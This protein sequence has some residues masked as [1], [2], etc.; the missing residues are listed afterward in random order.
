MPSHQ[1]SSD[2]FFLGS[3]AQYEGVSPS[4]ETTYRYRNGPLECAKFRNSRE[5]Q[6]WHNIVRQIVDV[7]DNVQHYLGSGRDPV[8]LCLELLELL[9][10][11]V[12]SWG[13]GL[14]PLVLRRIAHELRE[15]FHLSAWEWPP[16]VVLVVDDSGVTRARLPTSVDCFGMEV[17]E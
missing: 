7:H 12:E 8:T 11:F 15:E 4:H 5:G 1:A 14:M 2:V 3:V 16:I 17:A 9:D 10:F 13:K 6:L